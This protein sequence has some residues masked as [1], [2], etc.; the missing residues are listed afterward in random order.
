MQSF[1]RFPL[2]THESQIPMGGGT[3]GMKRTKKAA[4]VGM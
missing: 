3:C 1:T 4:T 2:P